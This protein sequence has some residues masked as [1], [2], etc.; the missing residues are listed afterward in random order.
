MAGS[1]KVAPTPSRK[2][3]NRMVGKRLDFGIAPPIVSPSG[4]SPS[5]SPSMK[6]IRPTATTRMPVAIIAA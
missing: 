1:A 2:A 5:R 6:N 4:I 3:N